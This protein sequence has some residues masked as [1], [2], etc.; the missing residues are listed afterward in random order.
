M[1]RSPLPSEVKCSK[2]RA[3]FCW[4]CEEPFHTGA[5]C[6][7]V[8]GIYQKWT[9]FLQQL[10]GGQIGG[11]L[12]ESGQIVNDEVNINS[13]FIKLEQA[14]ANNQYFKENFEAGNLK[15]CPSCKRLIEKL[16]GC[17]LMI[18]GQDHDGGVNN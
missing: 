12:V 4:K 11:R 15:Y 16:A 7:E 3:A 1:Y 5:S 13:A 6:L 8:K 9:T 17:D 2:C 14:M 10:A 18:C